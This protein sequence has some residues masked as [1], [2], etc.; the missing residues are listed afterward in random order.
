MR[1]KCMPRISRYR[2]CFHV[3]DCVCFCVCVCVFLRIVCAACE[4]VV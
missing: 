1:A 4:C 2:K 3:Y